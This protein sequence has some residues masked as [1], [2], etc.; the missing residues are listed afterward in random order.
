MTP[1]AQKF[2]R[3]IRQGSQNMGRLVD[4]LLNLSRKSAKKDITRQMVD[5]NGLVEGAVA[6]IKLEAG[7]RKL[8]MADRRIAH[9]GMRNPGPRQASLHQSGF[10]T[11]SNISRPREL[12]VIE[13]GLHKTVNGE[14]AIFVR[15]NGVG[16]NMK[17]SGK[18]F[19]VFQ[20]LHRAEE[21]EGTGVGLATVARIIRKHGGTHLGRG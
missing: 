4:D 12:A 2:A 14:S 11:P 10:P 3:K 17:Y 1:E 19:G 5:L 13:V 16:F 15:D 20:R 18:L 6:E 21:F 7:D 9:R 8:E